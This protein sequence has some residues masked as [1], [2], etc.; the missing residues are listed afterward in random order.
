MDDVVEGLRFNPDLPLGGCGIWPGL[1]SKVQEFVYLLADLT[2]EQLQGLSMESSM[3]FLREQLRNAYDLKESQVDRT[4]SQLIARRPSV[5]FILQPD[6]HPL[7][8]ASPGHATPCVNRWGLRRLRAR[9]SPDLNTRTRLRHVL[10]MMTSRLRRNVIY[11]C[12]HGSSPAWKNSPAV[13]TGWKRAAQRPPPRFMLLVL[14]GGGIIGSIP[15]PRNWYD[16]AIL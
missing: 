8:R 5:F 12:F 1:V 13:A 3:A 2:P 15:S 9:R 11:Q 7:A 4:R 6:R 10:D 14:V 16:F